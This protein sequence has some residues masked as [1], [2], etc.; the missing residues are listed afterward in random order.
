MNQFIGID[1]FRIWQTY[2][3][4][5]F[6]LMHL[7]LNFTCNQN[8]WGY[9]NQ[10]LPSDQLQEMKFIQKVTKSSLTK[11][12]KGPDLSHSF[13]QLALWTIR[14]QR[15]LMC[16]LKGSLTL[17]SQVNL[18]WWTLILIDSNKPS[19]LQHFL[20]RLVV[21]LQISIGVTVLY[22]YQFKINTKITSSV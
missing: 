13:N 12:I 19:F 10:Q 18:V 20:V 21:I 14:N 22:K 3:T 6:C 2:R 4:V 7:T 8:L 9:L 11:L 17:T 15:F 5:K 1:R 16:Q